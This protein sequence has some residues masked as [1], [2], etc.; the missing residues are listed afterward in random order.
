[1]TSTPRRRAPPRAL[2]VGARADGRADAQAPLLVL[3]C[4]RVAVG[5]E[6]VLDRDE[7]D[8]LAVLDDEELLDAVLVEELLGV[9]VRDA[10]RDRDELLRHQRADGLVEVLLEA[11]V[12]RREDADRASPPR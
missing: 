9:V 3:D 4:E 2:A 6:D 5:L 11:D 12:A 7:P 8:E 10:R 1:M